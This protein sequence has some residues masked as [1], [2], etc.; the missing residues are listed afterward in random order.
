[1]KKRA[2]AAVA[3]GVAFAA[4]PLAH[5]DNNWIAMAIS[6]STGRINIA[7][8]AA[9]Q[10]AAEKAVMDTCRKSISDCR[11][12]ASGDGG[13]LALAVNAAKSRYFGG[14]GPTR[15]EAEAAALARAPGGT[16]QPGHDH[17]AGEGSSQ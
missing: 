16:I 10:G 7:D 3:A 13:C 9:N 11:L 6:D 1:M 14:W 17:C 2:L 8:G 4:P 5:A 12:L 15:E